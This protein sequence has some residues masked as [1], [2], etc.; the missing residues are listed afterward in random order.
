MTIP[1]NPAT[2]VTLDELCDLLNQW[3]EF[4]T[5]DECDDYPCDI[6]SLPTF[7]G[8]EIVDTTEIC[9]WDDSR[10]LID[11]PQITVEQTGWELITRK[12]WAERRSR[13]D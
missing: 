13:D 6:T 3:A 10:V 1:R 2:A 11:G 8:P 12:E 4:L 9:S 5:H 7:G